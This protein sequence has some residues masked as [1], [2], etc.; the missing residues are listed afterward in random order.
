MGAGEEITAAWDAW[1]DAKRAYDD[2]AAP[3]VG[4]TWLPTVPAL[5]PSVERL[6]RQAFEKLM[7][8]GEAEHEAA[9]A[10]Y[11]VLDENRQDVSSATALRRRGTRQRTLVSQRM[12]VQRRPTNGAARLEQPPDVMF[13]ARSRPSDTSSRRRG[14][15]NQH[16][17][18]RASVFCTSAGHHA[19]SSLADLHLRCSAMPHHSGRRT[20]TSCACR[21]AST[22]VVRRRAS[23]WP[24]RSTAR[25]TT[26]RSMA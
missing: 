23:R 7:R 10:F 18:R 5:R 24:A 11:A 2:E 12:S 16:V 26:A 22:P 3:Y 9:A 4:V 1:R 21:A 13:A 19:A 15:R 20:C 17:R 8:L 14:R 6:T 25:S